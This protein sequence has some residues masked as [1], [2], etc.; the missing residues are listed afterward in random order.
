MKNCP[1]CGQMVANETPNCPYCGTAVPSKTQPVLETAVTENPKQGA[2]FD[3]PMEP[4][5]QSESLYRTA[6][7]LPSQNMPV[8]QQPYYSPTGY[9]MQASAPADFDLPM[10]FHHF[11]KWYLMI[12]GCLSALSC[13]MTLF[14]RDGSGFSP[15]ALLNAGLSIATGI[16][17]YKMISAGKVLQMIKNIL[18][19]IS[20]SIVT[21]LSLFLIFG[22][23]TIA[24]AVENSMM[25]VAGGV[26]VVFGF[27]CL[28]IG[29][30]AIVANALILK[31]YS[32]RKHLFH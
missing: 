18:E 19:I 21:L 23:G 13:L 17:L 7:P 20:G 32:K 28:L 12:T 16:C 11:Y 24:A 2:D 29:V 6:N 1:N 30:G 3:I 8:T 9:Q 15:I 25:S 5:P 26:F 4:L 31:Y 14:S 10:N 22:G 27:I